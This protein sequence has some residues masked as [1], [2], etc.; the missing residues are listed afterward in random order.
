MRKL[1]MLVTLALM[2]CQVV[3]FAIVDPQKVTKPLDI[4]VPYLCGI[5]M[6]T[7]DYTFDPAAY[8]PGGDS[9]GA[10]ECGMLWS[11]TLPWLL[12]GNADSCFTLTISTFKMDLGGVTYELDSA[13]LCD[14]GNR[15]WW[16][17]W[18]LW[19]AYD[20]GAKSEDLQV[21]VERLGY[22]DRAG[23]YVA[24]IEVTCWGCIPDPPSLP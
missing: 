3:T 7:G 11:N 22:A 10:A 13:F 16:M 20:H 4:P 24:L 5:G 21:G 17:S 8:S 1:L 6:P 19:H 23:T 15:Q 9:S 14:A 2:V 18:N 12:Y